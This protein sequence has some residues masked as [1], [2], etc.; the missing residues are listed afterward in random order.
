VV[1]RLRIV[2]TED[3]GAGSQE[4]RTVTE[5]W[6]FPLQ[7]RG[8][9]RFVESPV[10]LAPR[11]ELRHG[12]PNHDREWLDMP[13]PL[14]C[15]PI[16]SRE[17]NGFKYWGRI[18]GPMPPLGKRAGRLGLAPGLT[19]IVPYDP[20]W[21]REFERIRR[22]LHSLLPTARVEHVGSTAVPGCEAKPIL[23]L[24]VG[25]APGT[26]LRVDNAQSIGLEF[27]SVSPE[28]SLFVAT[29]RDGRRIAHVHVNPRNSGAEL[30][31]LRF[32]DYLRAHPN[33]AR[34]YA[35]TKRRALASGNA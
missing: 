21:P 26:R 8:D 32:R 19:Q 18:K 30:D 24:S 1:S 23:D 22:H 11:D 35:Q 15:P 10:E 4:S 5:P 9:L 31:F 14:L 33:V 13:F 34:A 2:V 28:S 3:I 25:L 27:R 7:K 12:C 20:E 29:G 17:G 6:Q 16:P